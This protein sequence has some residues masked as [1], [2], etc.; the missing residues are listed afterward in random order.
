[1]LLLA[2][3]CLQDYGVIPPPPSSRQAIWTEQVWGASPGLSRQ[4]FCN[5]SLNMKQIKV[6]LRA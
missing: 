4:I 2:C 5:R 6:R 1:M 3:C